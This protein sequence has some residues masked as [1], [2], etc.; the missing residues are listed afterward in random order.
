[1]RTYLRNR[2]DKRTAAP[3]AAAG[4][5]LVELLVVIAIIGTLVGLLLPAVQSA[6]E[7]ARRSM[8]SNNL[9]Q[10]GLALHNF[11]DA[12]GGRFPPPFYWGD[13]AFKYSWIAGILPW[14]EAQETYTKLDWTIWSGAGSIGQD[15]LGTT[16][17]QNAIR[18]FFQATLVCPS[19]PMLARQ[20]GSYS[21]HLVP[22]YAGI[23]GSSDSALRTVTSSTDRCWDTGAPVN[24]WDQNVS[25]YNG[26][27]ATQYRNTYSP[28]PKGAPPL[29][30]VG[31]AA[32]EIQNQG[33]ALKRIT[34]GL[35]NVLMLGEQSSWGIQADGTQNDCRSGGAFGWSIGGYADANGKGRVHNVVKIS[36]T[37]GTLSCD[38]PYKDGVKP[39]VSN[40]DYTIAFRSS[41]GPGAQFTR[42]D[43][44]VDWLDDGI[45]FTLYRLLAI[46]DSGSA[47]K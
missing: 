3:R 24:S 10:L 27:F 15:N 42:A 7:A 8:C 19:S 18:N 36:R 2:S 16:T 44:S 33:L 45:D 35:S 4:F 20:A 21:T 14:I 17:N 32:G 38:L 9:K 6:R 28:N 22:S 30:T 5:T 39:A 37:I 47:A 29:S 12:R 34:D 46:R 41:H 26:V 31:Q 25:C 43:G 11:A 1:M 23:A 13:A 40:V